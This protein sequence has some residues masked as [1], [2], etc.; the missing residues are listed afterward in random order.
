MNISFK[1]NFLN[2]TLMHFPISKEVNWAMFTGC[3]RINDGAFINRISISIKHSYV[4]LEMQLWDGIKKI[5]IIK[6]LNK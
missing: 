2:A 3:T 5:C 4:E 1:L 6:F